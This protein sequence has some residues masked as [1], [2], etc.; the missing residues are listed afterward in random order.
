MKKIISFLSVMVVFSGFVVLNSWAE[1]TSKLCPVNDFHAQGCVDAESAGGACNDCAYKYNAVSAKCINTA[2]EN[3]SQQAYSCAAMVCKEGT[4]MWIGKPYW[5]DRI[6]TMGVCHNAEQQATTCAKNCNDECHREGHTCKPRQPTSAEVEEANDY[7]G[8]GTSIA[9]LTT[10]NSY[11][12]YCDLSDP[13]PAGRIE[14]EQCANVAHAKKMEKD[15]D[16]DCKVKECDEGYEP[17]DDSKGCKCKKVANA[18]VNPEDCTFTCNKGYRKSKDGTGCVEVCKYTANLYCKDGTTSVQ[19]EFKEDDF[20]WADV[21]GVYNNNTK[22]WDFPNTQ[23]LYEYLKNNNQS[24][25]NETCKNVDAVVSNSGKPKVAEVQQ[26]A[27]CNNSLY[28][29]QIGELKRE[30]ADLKAQSN[31]QSNGVDTA[32]IRNAQDKLTKFFDALDKNRSVW[33]NADGSFNAVRLAS[34]LT[35]GVVLGTVGGVVSGVLIKKSQVEKG[36]DALNCT[37]GGQKI[38][39]WGDEFRVGLR[40]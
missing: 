4:K 6:L 28:T 9:E 34:D 22:K 1:T 36:F 37:V 12:C 35:A 20:N 32:K 15:A 8:Y 33:K 23:K 39:D 13:S 3:N 5:G 19:V 29:E 38:A 18:N 27:S 24:K 10:G 40:R 17:S 2:F 14:E 11:I 26:S 16:G 31:N 30:I 21:G 25:Y 7:S